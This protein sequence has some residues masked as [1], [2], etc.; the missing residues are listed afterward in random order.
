MGQGFAQG[1]Q[2]GQQRRMQRQQNKRAEQAH[3]LQM[4]QGELGLE[5]TRNEMAHRETMRPMEREQTGLKVDASRMEVEE[6]RRQQMYDQGLRALA[7]RDV[8]GLIG[9]HNEVN[10]EEPPIVEGGIERTEDGREILRLRDQ[11]G[12][13]EEFDVEE[14]GA[15]MSIAR[16]PELLQEQL[17]GSDRYSDPHMHPELG[18]GQ[19]GPDG[20]W[21]SIDAEGPAAQ[22]GGGAPGAPGTEAPNSVWA[23]MRSDYSNRYGIDGDELMAVYQTQGEEAGDRYLRERAGE[24]VPTLR[25][26]ATEEY[27]VDPSTGVFVR[28][29]RPQMQGQPQ[30]QPQTQGQPQGHPQSGG[31]DLSGMRERS[32]YMQN[33]P[34][35]DPA[36]ATQYAAAQLGHER[37][38]R[39]G[40]PAQ[41]PRREQPQA[42]PASTGRP[43]LP[44]D[45]QG[46]R[47]T[48]GGIEV[49]RFADQDA[50]VTQRG[51]WGFGV[52]SSAQMRGELRRAKPF[53]DKVAQ[54]ER[55]ERGE[56]AEAVRA[57]REGLLAPEAESVVRDW[58]R[59]YAQEQ[60][61]R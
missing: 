26:F 32:P 46:M 2:A 23:Q 10:T 34:D 14:L 44:E 6:A 60:Q 15:Q 50:R 42:G 53:F 51:M 56:L 37:G 9:W 41:Q 1:L 18:Y 27:G 61:A 57:A 7:Q 16:N 40:Q 11:E 38:L 25:E 8:D 47:E 58:A 35:D 33:L 12:N 49:P 28:D 22:G 30:G 5:Q 43:T 39:A 36:H 55:P 19:V 13:Q 54:G 17:A 52:G 59:R 21:H 4:D 45:L 29:M 31:L 3:G 24:G 48:E 20:Q